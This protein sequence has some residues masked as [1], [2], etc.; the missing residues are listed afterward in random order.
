MLIDSSGFTIFHPEANN[1][2]KHIAQ[3]EEDIASDLIHHLNSRNKQPIRTCHDFAWKRQYDTWHLDIDNNIN[4]GFYQVIPFSNTNLLLIIRYLEVDSTPRTC[5]SCPTLQYNINLTNHANEG[6][7]EC[8]RNDPTLCNCPCQSALD[9][10][11]CQNLFNTETQY[12]ICSKPVF[13]EYGHVNMTHNHVI[14]SECFPVDCAL[15]GME[16]ECRLRSECDWFPDVSRDDG[17]CLPKGTVVDVNEEESGGA[18]E[19]SK[20]GGSGETF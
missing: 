6:T 17:K 11:P 5:D 19:G 14:L 2:Y 12:P 16:F 9:F 13:A 20:G 1:Q 8:V 7:P 15:F 18:G 3:L 10:D 4:G